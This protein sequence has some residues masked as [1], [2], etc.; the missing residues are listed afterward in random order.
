MQFRV[1]SHNRRK[2]QRRPHVAVCAP[3]EYSLH[4]GPGV[5]FMH[6]DLAV[7]PSCGDN[8]LGQKVDPDAAHALANR[9]DRSKFQGLATSIPALVNRLSSLFDMSNQHGRR[10]FSVR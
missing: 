8:N 4:F 6:R 2:A 9:F 1:P 7:P 3:N 5:Q 10:R